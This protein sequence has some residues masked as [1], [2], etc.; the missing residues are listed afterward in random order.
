MTRPEWWFYSMNRYG[1]PDD[2]LAAAV[3]SDTPPTTDV[4]TN[5]QRPR[6]WLLPVLLVLFVL[7]LVIGWQVVGVLFGLVS[8]PEPPVPS[9]AEATGHRPDVYGFD[10]WSYRAG[11]LVSE[12]T[13]YYTQAGATCS[14]PPFSHDQSALIGRLFPQASNVVALCEGAE[15]FSR[16][17]MLYMAVIT[18]FDPNEALSYLDI[19]RRIDWIGD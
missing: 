4:T 17:T 6:R 16:F 19:S 10:T 13:L 7:A 2:A 3:E 12:L 9:F 18:S 8:L 11:A 14:T 5:S 1:H 15:T